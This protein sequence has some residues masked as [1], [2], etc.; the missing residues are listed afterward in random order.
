MD[1]PLKTGSGNFVKY[2]HEL[3]LPLPNPHL[4]KKKT[5]NKQEQT[6]I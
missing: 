6:S 4:Y 5:K 2:P 1:G 3:F